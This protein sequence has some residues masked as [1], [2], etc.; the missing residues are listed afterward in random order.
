VGGQPDQQGTPAEDAFSFAAYR[1][2]LDAARDSGYRFVAY[3]DDH[4]DDGSRLCLLRHD[5]DIDPEAAARIARIEHECGVAATYFVMVRSPVYNAFG[6]AN[7]MFFREIVDLGHRIG[8]HYDLAFRPYVRPTDEWIRRE[9]AVLESMLGVEVNVVS[10]HQPTFGAEDA[11][12][13]QSEGMISAFDFPGFVYVSD[14][15]KAMPEGSFVR[16]FS[17]ALIQRIHLCIHPI[18]WATDDPTADVAD[19]WDEAIIATLTR[20]Q[21]QILATERGFGPPRSITIVRR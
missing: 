12:S 2:M 15:N 6:R 20:S 10:F 4:P 7:E 5:V 9:A 1:R 8:L 14:A 13:V 11:R 16:L 3:D 17:E 18:W 21:Q 19:L